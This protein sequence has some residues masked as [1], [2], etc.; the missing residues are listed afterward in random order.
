MHSTAAST[1]VQRAHPRDSPIW[2][3]ELRVFRRLAPNTPK[4]THSKVCAVSNRPPSPTRYSRPPIVN[5]ALLLLGW[6]VEVEVVVEMRSTTQRASDSLP[7]SQQVYS[8]LQLKTHATPVASKTPSLCAW[9]PGGRGT[10][11]LMVQQQRLHRS[12]H[13]TTSQ[14]E[15]R[16]LKITRLQAARIL[17]LPCH[18]GPLATTASEAVRWWPRA[19]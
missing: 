17:A 4:S 2:R 10:R 5:A 14:H 11:R 18:R 8:V 7:P 6:N 1:P 13:H 9:L 15:P 3:A 12:H 19:L 16:S